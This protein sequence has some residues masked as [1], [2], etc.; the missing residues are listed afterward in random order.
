MQEK[1][2]AVLIP[3]LNEDKTIAKVVKDF[4][5]ELPK[6]QIYVF[7]NGST[8]KTAEKARNSGANV[9]NVNR[10][11]KGEV[12]KK[13]FDYIDANIY[14]MV[15]GDDTYPAEQVHELLNPVL[16]GDYDIVIGSRMKN[17]QKEEKRWLHN[18]GNRIIRWGVNFCFTSKIN[19]M[20]SGYRVMSREFVKKVNLLSKGFEVETE[21]TIKAL[22]NGYRIKEIPIDYKERPKGSESKLNSFSDGMYIL[23]TIINLF[24]DYRPIQ[25]FLLL[26][27]ISFALFIG[28]GAPVLIEYLNTHS[29]TQIFDFE[30]SLFFL[31][32]SFQLFVTGFIV[33]SV[34]SLRQELMNVLSKIRRERR[35]IIHK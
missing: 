32:I 24:R 16:S 15:D 28:F 34:H 4:K 19:D 1:K 18:A 12:V 5:N 23:T 31:L 20:L 27:C 14:V 21:L 2:I 7:D 6:S 33:S 8:D 10:K 3:A 30:L 11:G 26:S 25:F 35:E 9:I 17:F 22:E 13:M 29:I